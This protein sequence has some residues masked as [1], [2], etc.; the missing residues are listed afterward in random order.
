[1]EMGDFNA[2]NSIDGM[3]KISHLFCRT[4]SSINF[5]YISANEERAESLDPKMATKPI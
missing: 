2:C 3:A 5:G 4:K 1:M